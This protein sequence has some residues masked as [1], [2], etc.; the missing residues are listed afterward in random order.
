MKNVIGANLDLPLSLAAV[1]ARKATMGFRIVRNA[2]ARLTAQSA[3]MPILGI[4]SAR[5]VLRAN[6]VISVLPTTH[7][8]Q[9]AILMP[10]N[11]ESY[12]QE[13]LGKFFH[14][15]LKIFITASMQCNFFN[16][17]TLS[18]GAKRPNFRAK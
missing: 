16:M 18:S 9:N 15:A 3:A 2:N 8:F 4:V 6:L 12:L 17:W 7:P 14:W 1:A 13:K 5:V 10:R 11:Q